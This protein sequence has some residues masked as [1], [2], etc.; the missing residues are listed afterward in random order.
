MAHTTTCATLH[1]SCAPLSVALGVFFMVGKITD[2]SLYFVPGIDED[3]QHLVDALFMEG[4]R[5]SDYILSY[6]EELIRML[7]AYDALASELGFIDDPLWYD[8]WY[9]SE[10]RSYVVSVGTIRVT[11]SFVTGSSIERYFIARRYPYIGF[12]TVF[13]RLYSLHVL[14]G[15]PY[16][17][18]SNGKKERQRVRF[19]HHQKQFM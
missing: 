5:Y 19:L 16:L 2:A 3:N 12:G 17:D 13:E 8:Q 4:K 11:V 1:A 10:G 18:T 14:Y 9:E 6:W 15:S 7:Q